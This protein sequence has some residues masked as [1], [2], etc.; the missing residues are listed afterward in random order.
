MIDWASITLVFFIA[1]FVINSLS[2]RTY[3][4]PSEK[5]REKE[6][7]WESSLPPLTPEEIAADDKAERM[8][9]AQWRRD[10]GLNY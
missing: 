9:V 10:Q 6:R 2:Q 7:A 8:A 5:E 1:G 4:G 3:Y